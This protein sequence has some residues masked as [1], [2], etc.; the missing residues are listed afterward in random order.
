MEKSELRKK[1]LKEVEG[2]KAQKNAISK[3]IG[4]LKRSKQNAD[5]QMAES[6][7][8]GEKIN[9]LEERLKDV[10]SQVATSSLMSRNTPHASVPAG[11]DSS[12]NVE[13]RNSGKPG[14]MG[15]MPKPHNEIGEAL[16]I[17]NFAEGARLSGSRFVVY[18]GLGAALERALINFML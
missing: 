2:L 15:F 16:G 4:E 5:R 12:A 13:K 3:E 18:H 10:E 6:K 11:E 1:L 14:D 17:L 8:L 9:E 7:K